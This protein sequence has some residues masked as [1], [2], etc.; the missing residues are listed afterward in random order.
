MLKSRNCNYVVFNEVYKCINIYIY[1]YICIFYINDGSLSG[2]LSRK[3]HSPMVSAEVSK[4]GPKK[5][6]R[7]DAE[8][9]PKRSPPGSKISKSGFQAVLLGGVRARSQK[10]SQ[11][12]A[13][14]IGSGGF[15][16]QPE[17]KLRFSTQLSKVPKLES[18]NLPNGGPGAPL[19]LPKA[20]PKN[21]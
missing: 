1:I 11:S 4:R 9:A 7:N 8:H 17:L 5:C 10:T 18:K 6:L 14:Q 3:L 13:S 16:L 12:G 2:G 15:W 19:Y 20:L 21:A